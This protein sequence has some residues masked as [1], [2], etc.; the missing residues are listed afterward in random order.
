MPG[1]VGNN[2]KGF[3][4]DLDINKLNIELLQFISHDWHTLTP[5]PSEELKSENLADLRQKAIDLLRKK[6][7]SVSIF[8]IKDPRM[9]RLLPFWQDIFN[10]CKLDVSYVSTIQQSSERCRIALCTRQFFKRKV[11]LYVAGQCIAQHY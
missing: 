5:I 3:W 8:G 7:K 1:I 10:K 11:L 9:T 6:T 2:E 4:E